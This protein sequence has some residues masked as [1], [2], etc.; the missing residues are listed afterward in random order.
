VENPIPFCSERLTRVLTTGY[1]HARYF[2]LLLAP[3]HLSCDWSWACIPLVEHWEDPRNLATAGLYLG[4]LY[5]L[6]AARPL[7][8]AVGKFKEW[9]ACLRSQEEPAEQEPQQEAEQ[10]Q[11]L[12]LWRARV[13]LLVVLGLVVGPFFPATN[14]LFYVGTFIGERLLYYP[15]I[16]YCWLVA[17][18]LGVLFLS[19]GGASS[20]SAAA[21]SQVNGHPTATPPP[22][23]AAAATTEASGAA[24]AAKP[25]TT[26]TSS[27]SSSAGSPWRKRLLLGVVGVVLAA[28]AARTWLRNM[29]WVDEEALF[30]AAQKVCPDSAKVQHNSGI[31]ERRYNRFDMALWRFR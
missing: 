19:K 9:W 15:S 10:G 14:I 12:S 6:L 3:L 8:L 21:Q 28:Y 25:T 23:A 17:D 29:D 16:G 22:A 5:Y 24:A 18:L 7:G 31:L 4:L 2:L 30:V 26:T 27:N 1:L 11:E 13:R 20:S